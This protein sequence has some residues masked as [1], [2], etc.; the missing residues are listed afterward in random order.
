MIVTTKYGKIEKRLQFILMHNVRIIMGNPVRIRNRCKSTVN[1]VSARC[2]PVMYKGAVWVYSRYGYI[3]TH[4][5][6]FVNILCNNFLTL[7]ICHNRSHAIAP[8]GVF[9]K[10][11]L[12]DAKQN[13][14][15]ASAKMQFIAFCT[16]KGRTVHRETCYWARSEQ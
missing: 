2:F 3:L 13:P 12:R 5:V 15:L 8:G 10:G 14:E 4:L 9:S 11:M 16:L 1:K 7:Y 6:I